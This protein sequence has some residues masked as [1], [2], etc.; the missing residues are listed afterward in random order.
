M[1]ASFVPATL[2][3]YGSWSRWWDAM[4]PPIFLTSA[5]ALWIG[6]LA[7]NLF[8]LQVVLL[9]RLPWL[10]KAFG[11]AA[12][13]AWHRR[14]AH[15]S[16]WLTL[17]HVVLFVNQRA[18]R[19]P[20]SFG[21]SMLQLFVTDAWMLVATIGTLLIV[22]VV[23]SS[24]AAATER[25]RYETW[26]LTHLWSYVGIALAL[27]HQLI[28]EDFNRTGSLVYWWA[29]YLLGLGLLV[30]GRVVV[31]AWRS[32]RHDLRIG[33]VLPEGP[34]AVSIV[35]NGR[36]LDR[37]GARAGQFFI[38]RFA[39][40]SGVTRG[41]PYS[42]SASPA[43]DR[44]RVTIAGTGDGARR[45]RRLEAG[46][47]VAVEGPYGALPW[48]RRRHPRLVMFAAGIGITPVR[49]LLEAPELQGTEVTVVTRFSSAGR[50]VL[51]GE[52]ERIAAA[53]G[54][55]VH[56]LT[57]PRAAGHQW[58]GADLDTVID[59]AELVRMLVPDIAAADIVLCGPP[60]WTAQ[61]RRAVEAAGA[62]RR[63]VHEEQF[64][65]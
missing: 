33:E 48:I 56:T 9:A 44:L 25:L 28:S 27:P 12:L 24:L 63:D 13:T 59:P 40:P 32:I 3:A 54:F 53:R 16:F 37:W 2:I 41:H 29:L 55:V 46:A 4:T 45:A 65:W 35:V 17:L 30:G 51:L 19:Q 20:Q 18:G 39:G 52:V 1:I 61:V 31:P 50:A 47:R 49:A 10:E 43:D 60:S 6:L 11:R 57:G 15:W 23:L 34:D 7:S 22:L 64:T 8:V 5:E 38:W 62:R 14:L 21:E 26:H 36:N 58:W 42:L